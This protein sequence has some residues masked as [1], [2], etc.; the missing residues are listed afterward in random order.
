[1]MPPP[2]FMPGSAIK[3]KLADLTMFLA[4]PHFPGR[5]GEMEAASRAWRE[6]WQMI[7]Q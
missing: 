3:T 4:R 5:P 1:M 6:T 2:A 7:G